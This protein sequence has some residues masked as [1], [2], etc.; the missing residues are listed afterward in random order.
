VK[1]PG[2]C[3]VGGRVVEDH[4]DSHVVVSEVMPFHLRARPYS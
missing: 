2:P 1:S 3:L 4:G